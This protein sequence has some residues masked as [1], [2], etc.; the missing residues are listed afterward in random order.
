MSDTAQPNYRLW[1]EQECRRRADVERI[2]D[3]VLGENEGD[4][5]GAGLVADVALA[6]KRAWDQ[7]F[8]AGVSAPANRALGL[9]NP[10]NPYDDLKEI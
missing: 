5:A 2:L 9:G 6:V 3:R 8:T 1:W 4:G 10:A 7:G